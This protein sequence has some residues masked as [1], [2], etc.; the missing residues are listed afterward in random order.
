VGKRALKKDFSPTATTSGVGFGAV[1]AA[2]NAASFGKALDQDDGRPEP[3]E[4][5]RA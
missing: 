4:P 2:L 1:W 5:R 3:A